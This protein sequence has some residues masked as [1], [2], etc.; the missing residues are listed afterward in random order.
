M[1]GEAS[2]SDARH[3]HKHDHGE[4]AGGKEG[5]VARTMY[6]KCLEE[7][8]KADLLQRVD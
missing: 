1:E 4:A 6:V 3:K 7:N 5:R 2:P 8:G